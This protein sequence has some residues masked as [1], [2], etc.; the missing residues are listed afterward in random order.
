[1]GAVWCSCICAQFLIHGDVQ[2]E[3]AWKLACA[4]LHTSAFVVRMKLNMNSIQCFVHE[5][6]GV[7]LCVCC[8]DISVC[9]VRT[10]MSSVFAWCI[11]MSAYV[12]VYVFAYGPW[13]CASVCAI[14][15][16]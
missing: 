2:T 15:Y 9:V 3:D 7:C 12:P 11:C 6:S 14:M 1:M 8:V 4:Q 5:A 10:C 13:L 16:F